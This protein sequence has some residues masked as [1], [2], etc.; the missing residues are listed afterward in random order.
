[1][2]PQTPSPDGWKGCAAG[3]AFP[4]LVIDLHG[5]ALSSAG[6]E[7]AGTSHAGLGVRRYRETAPGCFAVDCFAVEL[8]KPGDD[9]SA[10]T[11]ACVIRSVVRAEPG[12]PPA[13]IAIFS[14]ESGPTP[15]RRRF[16]APDPAT[17]IDFVLALLCQLQGLG[18]ICVDLA[19]LLY[20]W[21]PHSL[22][23]VKT[24]AGSPAGCSLSNG[25][26]VTLFVLADVRHFDLALVEKLCRPFESANA[27]DPPLL[28]GHVLLADGA[29]TRSIVVWR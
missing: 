23:H 10:P 14:G 19:D 15:A 5:F 27:N 12:M 6:L 26:P 21:S 9:A 20:A 28:V 29:P 25:V 22:H 7:S 18:G 11:F 16:I 8:L 1:M 3:D 4:Q 17:A 2:S 24:F 13:D